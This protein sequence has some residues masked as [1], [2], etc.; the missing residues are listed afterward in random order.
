MLLNCA[1]QLLLIHLMYPSLIKVLILEKKKIR[2]GPKP[3]NGSVNLTVFLN[4]LDVVSIS[5]VI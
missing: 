3:K 4:T 1:F 5:K 2:T